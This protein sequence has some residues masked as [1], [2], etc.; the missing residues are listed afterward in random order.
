MFVKS[1]DAYQ[2]LSDAEKVEFHADIILTNLRRDGDLSKTQISALF[3][4][5]LSADQ[6]N[7][8]LALLLDRR[9]AW[10]YRIM[11]SHG[12]PAMYWSVS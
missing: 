2:L 8:A 1:D 5:N 12:R 4:R 11:K 3:S 6:I 9:Q 7:E 10:S